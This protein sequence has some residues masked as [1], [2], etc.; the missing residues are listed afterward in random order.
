MSS[1]TAAHH[2]G[3]AGHHLVGATALTA[4]RVLGLPRGVDAVSRV[5]RLEALGEG[6][7]VR[8]SLR[9]HRGLVRGTVATT[10]PD[11]ST[12]E[13][14]VLAVRKPRG[15]L[16]IHRGPSTGG[17]RTGV[18]L[19]VLSGPGDRLAAAPVGWRERGLPSRPTF[20][21]DPPHP[22]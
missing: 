5:W 21:A 14:A 8:L 11:G 15:V 1:I 19:F 2:P 6:H 12:E 7:A 3:R 13:L 10:R 17:H 18:V 4:A 22:T 20:V 16:V 9:G